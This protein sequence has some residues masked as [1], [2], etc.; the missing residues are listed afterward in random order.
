MRTLSRR[1]RAPVI[2]SMAGRV[3]GRA[4]NGWVV[5]DKPLGPT[6]S[7]V[8]GRVRRLFQ[9]RKAGHCGTLDPLATG[10]LPIAFGEATKT[11]PYVTEAAKRYRFT[12]RWGV[13]TTTDDA[14]G[15]AI[16]ESSIR[17]DRTAIETTLKSFIGPIQQVPPL[18]SAVK[19]QGRRA[20]DLARS[21]A[22]FS[23]EPRTIVIHALELSE[24]PDAEHATFEA[25]CGKGAYMRALA[26]DIGR[27]LG[28][29]AH[30]TALRR[31]SVGPFGEDVAISLD[32]LESL[33]HIPAALEGLLPIEAALDD[34]PALVLNEREATRLRCGQAVSFV[35]RIDRERIGGLERGTIVLARTGKKL[36]ALARY[37]AGEIRPVR[38][39]NL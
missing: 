31:L 8:V 38:V 26:R 14:E 7:E 9:A 1:I 13:S 20:Y 18:Y 10:I 5:I 24:V 4:V 25:A 17:P 15:D 3:K 37:E 33:G 35:S 29:C 11:I 12:L 2:E 32:Y 36:V 39:L 23:L 27:A 28:T 30:V 19:V 22:S 34:I 21:D 16:E 6:S